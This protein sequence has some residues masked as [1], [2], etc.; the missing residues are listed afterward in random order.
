MG[1]SVYLLH[2]ATSD[3]LLI[4]DQSIVRS[5]GFPDVVLAPDT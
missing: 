2:L 1:T 4:Q 3:A 5:L